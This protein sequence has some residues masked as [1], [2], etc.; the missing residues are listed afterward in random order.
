MLWRGISSGTRSCLENTVA[1]YR[2][3]PL[4]LSRSRETLPED[5]QDVEHESRMIPNEAAV[6]RVL[7]LPEGANRDNNENKHQNEEG[8]LEADTNRHD[9]QQVERHG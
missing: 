6:K 9:G 4:R 1:A 7:L 2:H 8:A 3:D 5:V